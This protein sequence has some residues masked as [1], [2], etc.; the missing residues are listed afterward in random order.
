[1]TSSIDIHVRVAEAENVAEGIKRLKLV[2]ANGT[3]LPDFSAGAHTIVA[4]T[5]GNR[6]RRNP[7]S[8]MGTPGDSSCYEI[9]VLRTADSRGGSAFIHEHVGVGTELSI[10]PPMNLFPIDRR[11]RRHLLIAGGI[12]ITPIMA[13]MA[14][15]NREDAAFELHYAMRSARH[16]AYWPTLRSLY[17]HRVHTYSDADGQTLQLDRLLEGQPLGTHLYVCGPAGMIDWVLQSARAAGWPNENV[18]SERFSAPPVGQPFTVELAKSKK[19]VQVGQHES[20][21]EAL[22]A[23]GVD[24]TYLCRGGACGQCETTVLSCTGSLVHNDHY[25]SDEER[26]SAKKI[27]LCVSRLEGAGA[28]AVLDL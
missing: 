3:P 12:G 2:A 1:M 20:L 24:P 27:M 8:L 9:S 28:T 19:T 4:M 6:E 25:L 13:M 18:H 11:A 10:S 14:E 26:A 5:D 7:Y 16:G 21:L 15:L 22:E 17:G 23:A